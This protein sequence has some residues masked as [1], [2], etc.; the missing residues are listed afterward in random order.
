MN[1]YLKEIRTW[2]WNS[3]KVE[4]LDNQEEN[5]DGEIE[6]RSFLGTCFN[7]SPSGKYYTPIANSNVDP[8]SKCKGKGLLGNKCYDIGLNTTM[9]KSVNELRTYAVN[10]YG[11]WS[12]G[13]WPKP[14]V[15]IIEKLDKAI[16]ETQEYSECDKCG[17]LGSEEGYQDELFY[18][19]LEQVAGEYGLFITEGEGDP[20]DIFAGMSID[21]GDSDESCE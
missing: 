18:E 19:A 17:G 10:R 11:S 21:K 8:C 2:N 3:V 5:Y 7:M 1:P 9:F 16:K 15:S 13:K 4:C 12:N 20:C 14:L 6:G